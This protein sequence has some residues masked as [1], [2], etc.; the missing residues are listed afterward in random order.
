MVHKVSITGFCRHFTCMK[1]LWKVVTWSMKSSDMKHEM[2]L[3][4]TM[5]PY[6]NVLLKT[7]LL[8]VTI[9][10]LVW[11]SSVK[12]LRWHWSIRKSPVNVH[13]TLSSNELFSPLVITSVC[14]VNGWRIPGS[15]FTFT[16][17]VRFGETFWLFY[18]NQMTNMQ[19]T[20]KS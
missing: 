5:G 6:R 17:W 14:V 10:G 19:G 9:Y 16:N 1:T 12:L 7:P 18:G 3:F 13:P 8:F 15:R 2:N 11:N 4:H 20:D